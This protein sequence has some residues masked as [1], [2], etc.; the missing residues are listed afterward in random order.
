MSIIDSGEFIMT[1]LVKLTNLA[2]KK[3]FISKSDIIKWEPALI[4][5]RV[6]TRIQLNGKS[7]SLVQESFEEVNSKVLE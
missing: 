7:D 3:I 6:V 4:E 1:Q 5:N 2:D